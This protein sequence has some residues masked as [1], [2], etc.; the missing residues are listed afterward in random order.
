MFYFFDWLI[1]S[2]TAFVH[3]SSGMFKAHSGM[4]FAGR[5]KVLI[6]SKTSLT[7]T[8]SISI[9]FLLKLSSDHTSLIKVVP[10]GTTGGKEEAV[11]SA[12]EHAP[13]KVLF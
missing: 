2:Y 6:A 7:L 11:F 13:S 3:V 10:I 1:L 5:V 12:W 8:L 9:S 4:A